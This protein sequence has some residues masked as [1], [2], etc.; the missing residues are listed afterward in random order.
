[1]AVFRYFFGLNKFSR[2]NGRLS[3]IACHTYWKAMALSY[4]L[5]YQEIISV[6]PTRQDFCWQ[7][8]LYFLQH[9][10][11]SR[12]DICLWG[13]D[14]W[15]ESWFLLLDAENAL[16]RSCS[17]RIRFALHILTLHHRPA[18]PMHRTNNTHVPSLALAIA[19]YGIYRVF[20]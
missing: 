3:P 13:C 11:M 15:G 9:L 17:E 10:R 16:H 20:F 4:N 18:Q 1:M 5:A 6:H 12:I 8:I 7:T 2:P 14:V 19:M